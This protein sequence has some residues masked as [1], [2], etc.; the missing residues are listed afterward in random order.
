MKFKFVLIWESFPTYFAELCAVFLVGLLM[1]GTYL[2]QC[3]IN[4]VE[5][6]SKTPIIRN[7]N[8]ENTIHF[9]AQKKLYFIAIN[10]MQNKH[11]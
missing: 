11:T 7:R 8:I 9:T 10:N 2:N 4:S 3:K 6:Q 1:P 5:S